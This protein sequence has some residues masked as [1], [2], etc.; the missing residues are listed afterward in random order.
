MTFIASIVVLIEVLMPAAIVASIRSFYISR[1]FINAQSSLFIPYVTLRA[2]FDTLIIV[3]TV[4]TRG[5]N[6]ASV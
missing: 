3:D 6:E 5:T 2:H 1:R 4:S